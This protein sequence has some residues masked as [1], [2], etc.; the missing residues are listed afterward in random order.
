M[1]TKSVSMRHIGY[2]KEM[3]AILQKIPIS[4]WGT[5][6]HAPHVTAHKSDGASLH[7]NWLHPQ[8]VLMYVIM[9]MTV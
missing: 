1:G 2:H 3:L 6:L 5:V 4:Y 7:N 9:D 8:L